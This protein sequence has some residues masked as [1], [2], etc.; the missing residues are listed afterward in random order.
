MKIAVCDDNNNDRKILL[1]ML[2]MYCE[3]NGLKAD[4]EMF[5]SGS[6]LLRRMKQV[7]FSI[8]FLDIFLENEHGIDLARTIRKHDNECLLFFGTI[9][10]DFALDGFEVNALHY[11]VKPF[12]YGQIENAM[13][14]C[15]DKL[16]SLA[17]TLVLSLKQQTKVFVK[18]IIFVEALDRLCYI[19]TA[20][21]VESTRKTIKDLETELGTASFLRCHRSYIVNLECVREYTETD[22]IL[23]DG[24][25]VPIRQEGRSKIKRVFRNYLTM[26]VAEKI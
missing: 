12:T 6:E 11:L 3:R 26:R 18:D 17:R 16:M 14:R 21:G 8:A 1:T 13:D 10:K 25:R 15:G 23:N 5:A 7:S 2:K 20:N 9:S 19:H 4:I 22:F 24:M